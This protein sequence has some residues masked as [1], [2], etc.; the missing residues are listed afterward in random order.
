MEIYVLTHDWNFADGSNGHFEVAFASLQEA[1]DRFE[2][3][4]FLIETDHYDF[5]AK[6]SPY[7]E[8]DMSFSA[9]EK[10]DSSMNRQDLILRQLE[11]A[12]IDFNNCEGGF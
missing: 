1:F 6:F 11:V 9:Y 4:K 2:W 7:C 3:Y 10:E 12:D 5:D 8:G